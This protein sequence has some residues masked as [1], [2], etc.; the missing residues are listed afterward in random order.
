MKQ[1][2]TGNGQ[3]N[4]RTR[5][6]PT[7]APITLTP[8]ATTPTEPKATL[9]AALGAPLPLAPAPAPVPVAE[10]EGRGVLE[11]TG[12]LPLA[13]PLTAGPEGRADGAPVGAA[14]PE[15][16]AEAESTVPVNQQRE[17]PKQGILTY[18]W[19]LREQRQHTAVVEE[20]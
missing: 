9:L 1:T 2:A 17:Q 16:E 14:E 18:R 13:E 20:Q 5:L 4:Q 6:P 12:R 19:R 11:V 15:A 8:R 10:P 3:A 7:R